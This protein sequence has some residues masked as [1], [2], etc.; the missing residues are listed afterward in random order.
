[1]VALAA[2]FAGVAYG[3]AALVAP[4]SRGIANAL[5]ELVA[6][7]SVPE[8]VRPVDEAPEQPA[9]ESERQLLPVAGPAKPLR[10]GAT[11]PAAPLKPAALFVSRATVIQ[12]AESAARPRGAFVPQT[13]EHPAGLRLA[14]VAALGIGVQDGDILIEALGIAPRAP[15]E[16]IGAVIEARAKNARFL[17]G[18]LWRRGDTFRITVEQ[19][20]LPDKG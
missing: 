9:P 20:Y 17:S 5:I 8:P 6:P 2:P 4:L 1:M 18:T 13:A 12:L 19:P 11:R 7:L 3:A 14:G 10:R 16:I 15:G